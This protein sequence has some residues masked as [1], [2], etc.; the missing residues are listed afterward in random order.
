MK[1]VLAVYYREILILKRKMIRQAAS[2]SISPFLYLI[3]FGFGMGK[4]ISIGGRSY[5]EFLIPGLVAMNSMA[6]AFGISAEI[7]VARFYW[8]IF[9]EIQSSPISDAAYVTGETLAG[10]R[11]QLFRFVLFSSLARFQALRFH[12]IYIY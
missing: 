2:M 1:G 11:A 7:N 9:D 6:H 12:I 10:I 3:A 8:G 5:L 4:E